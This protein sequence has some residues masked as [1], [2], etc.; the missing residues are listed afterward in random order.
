M[1]S[2]IARSLGT[3][4]EHEKVL[5]IAQMGIDFCL[6]HET[7]NALSHLLFYKSISLLSLNRVEEGKEEAKKCIM[8]L[9]IENNPENLSNYTKVIEEAF[10][11]KVIN[12]IKF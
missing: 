8:Q 6:K 2:S 3:K 5:E 9:Y 1:N 10:N 12:L 11:T 4:G 7:S